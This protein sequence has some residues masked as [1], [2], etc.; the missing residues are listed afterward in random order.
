MRSLLLAACVVLSA[1]G[2]ARSAP[3]EPRPTLDVA[4]LEEEVGQLAERARPARLQVAIQAVDGGA[5]WMNDPT[6]AYPM[7]SVFKAPLGAAVLAR[8]DAGQLSLGDVVVL[9][10]ADMAPQLSPVAAAWPA[11]DRYTIR[12]LLTAA[13]RDSDNTA[14]DVLM[15][16]IGG[17]TALT[18][19]LRSRGVTGVDV[20]RY[21]RELQVQ[22]LGMPAFQPDWRTAEPFSRAYRTVP[23]A[24]RRAA[25]TRYQADSRDTITAAGALRFLVALQRGDLVS[26][27]STRLLLDLMTETKTGPD[28]LKAGLPE[29]A[30]LAH[31]TGTSGTNF[32]I[33]V[34]TNDMGLVTLADG[35]TYAVAV[36]LANSPASADERAAILAEA[37]RIVARSIP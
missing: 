29:G 32:G 19:W 26:P 5:P 34:A 7:Q 15:R 23:E 13:V 20:D 30:R 6:G 12:D 21:E 22:A 14:A 31:K 8:V 27:T 2:A 28:R 16:R 11:K 24:E 4:R 17:P 36:F 25:W 33:T 9:T 18:A 10:E 37:M 1:C 35:R 3:P